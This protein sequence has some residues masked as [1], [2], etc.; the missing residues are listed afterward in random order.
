MEIS[1]SNCTS[2][3]LSLPSK[4]PQENN[5]IIIIMM[6]SSCFEPKL[7]DIGGWN[8]ATS[9]AKKKQ[10]EDRKKGGRRLG[11]G[12]FVRRLCGF[13]QWLET[14]RQKSQ[15]IWFFLSRGAQHVTVF[16]I[17]EQ[18]VWPAVI[19]RSPRKTIVN[20]IVMEREREKTSIFDRFVET[21]GEWESGSGKKRREK[22]RRISQ[23]VVAR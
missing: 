20:N 23:H 8:S 10:N 14:R 11:K 2:I 17:K 3:L 4:D 19:Q 13:I 6:I 7:G 1:I 12:S 21:K 9:C 5:C 22:R 18:R 16:L 15:K